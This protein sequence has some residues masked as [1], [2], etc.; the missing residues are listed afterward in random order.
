MEIKQYQP[1]HTAALVELWYEASVRAHHFIPAAFW[2]ANREKMAKLYLPNSLS[3]VAL[4][5]ER[6]AGFISM[7]GNHLAA[8]FVRPELQGKGIGSRLL[9]HV[10]QLHK[11]LQLKVYSRNV[12]ALQ[13]YLKQGFETIS[14][15]LEEASGEKE[16]LMRWDAQAKL[17]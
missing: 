6:P 3:F 14:E 17:K 11:E 7:S 8:L 2:E 12:S 16:L 15:N 9:A 5:G 13:F 10:K 4:Q 1:E